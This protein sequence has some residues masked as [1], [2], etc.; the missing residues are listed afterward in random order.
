MRGR[1]SFFQTL[2]A[3]SLTNPVRSWLLVIETPT[4]VYT[5]FTSIYLPTVPLLTPFQTYGIAVTA[6]SVIRVSIT[7]LIIIEWLAY[8]RSNLLLVFV[9][10]A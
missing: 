10:T 5:L 1:L 9:N 3:G 6:T 2:I 8:L 7:S 4:M